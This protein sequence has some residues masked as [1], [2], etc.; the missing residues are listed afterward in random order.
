MKNLKISLTILFF[1]IINSANSQVR[2]VNSSSNSSAS[3]SSAFIDASSNSTSNATTNIGKGLLYPRVDLTTFASFSGSPTGIGTSYPTRFDGMVVYNTGTGNTLSSASTTIV[4][5]T[6]G[7][8]YYNNKS[9]TLT[10]GVW[11]PVGENAVKF[12]DGTTTADAVFTGGKVG[13]GTTSPSASAALEVNSTTSGILISRMN[14]T[15]RGLITSPAN[16]LLIFNTSNNS[17]EVYKSTCSCWVTMNDNGNTAAANL[18]NNAPSVSNINYKGVFRIN[19]T[20]NVVYTYSDP[21]ND[22]EATTTIIWEIANDNNGTARTTHTTGAS[23][24]FAAAD[25]GKYVRVK[26]TPRAATGILNGVETYGGWALIDAALK[27]YATSV[28][29]TG[30]TE[31]GSTLTGSY[32][33]NG[34]TNGSTTYTENTIGS[35]YQW[36]RASSNKGLGISNMAVP[37]GGT[38][39]GKTIRPTI[40][41]VNK[42]VRFGVQAKDNLSNSSSN[43]VYSDWVGP[44]TLAAEAAPV[45]K[46]VSY[47]PTPGA[48]ITSKASYTYEDAN[49]DPEGTSIYKW[50]SATDANGTNQTAITSATSNE[51]LI[52]DDYA[53]K[54]IGV[55]ITPKAHT[56]NQTGTEV[57][58]YAPAPSIPAA[59]FTFVSATQN[60]NSF[61]INRVMAATDTITVGINVT[62]AGSIKFTT[63]TVNGYSFSADGVY[64]TGL[65][66]V[67]LVAKGTQT[68]YNSSGDNFTITGLGATSK[69]TAIIINNVKLGNQI[70]SHFN[71]IVGGVHNTTTPSDPTYNTLSSYTT[72]ES[73]NNNTICLTKPISASACVGTSIT[74]GSNTYPITNING[75]C[76]MTQNLKEL[77]NGAAINASSGTYGYYNSGLTTWGLSE[78]AA[79]EGLIYFWNAAMLGSTIERTRGVCPEG[80][81]IPSDCEWMYLEHGLGMEIAEQVKSQVSRGEATVS[82]GTVSYK[83]RSAGEFNTN[84]SGFSGLI[85]GR[86]ELSGTFNL[87]GYQAFYWSSTDLGNGTA[88][89]RFYQTGTKGINRNYEGKGLGS[90]V[91]CLKD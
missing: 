15:Q 37:D 9:N 61:H 35:N 67:I 79:G 34:G 86:R 65:Q 2:I 84:A 77:P 76:W 53:G 60:G 73:F 11:K 55:G 10:G 39:F 40:N 31:Q 66:N 50:Y 33:F 91:R 28:N 58:Y 83:L 3:N 24:T 49:N 45:A 51:F 48:N 71:G 62:S 18:A 64:N 78:P 81:H 22:A 26:I 56:G 7:F 13:I 14:S 27:S 21:E 87:R 75:Q 47:S 42:Y 23:P 44:I 69:T 6:P 68:A 57:V 43:Y 59:D 52:T 1:A 54:Y 38:A 4:A 72:G 88:W 17:F 70:T 89:A 20:A 41:D 19:G 90:Y 5:V 63:N 36:Q 25:A 46:N 80:W 85:T 32:T 8:Y 12:K 74:I 82:M 16:G 30:T 29:V